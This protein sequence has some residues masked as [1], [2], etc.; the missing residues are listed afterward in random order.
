MVDILE[1]GN[2]CKV[3]RTSEK[4]RDTAAIHLTLHE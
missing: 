1:F 4:T 3:N 2:I